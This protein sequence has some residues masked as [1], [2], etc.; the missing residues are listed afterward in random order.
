M[1]LA[2]RRSDLVP[3]PPPTSLDSAGSAGSAG[4]GVGT[5]RLEGT[6][7]SDRSITAVNTDRGSWCGGISAG[8][9]CC[10]AGGG[11]YEH[12]LVLERKQL[13]QGLF[14]S[15]RSLL[16][17]HGSHTRVRRRRLILGIG[18]IW[19]SFMLCEEFVGLNVCRMWF[20]I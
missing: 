14:R 5:V 11:R 18:C 15:H 2:S 13:L 16:C 12:D 10:C 8:P 20:G 3:P 9:L 19:L 1:S 6:R 4:S 7:L 17:R